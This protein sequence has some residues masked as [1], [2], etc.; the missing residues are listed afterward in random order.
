[1]CYTIELTHSI[2]YP[3]VLRGVHSEVPAE[4]LKVDLLALGLLLERDV[5]GGHYGGA[6]QRG[7]TATRRAAQVRHGRHA[8][9]AAR[10]RTNPRVWVWV[11]VLGAADVVVG[12]AC[13]CPVWGRGPGGWRRGARLQAALPPVGDWLERSLP[14]EVERLLLVVVGAGG[15]ALL[16]PRLFAYHPRL[17]QL[18]TVCPRSCGGGISSVLHALALLAGVDILG[19]VAVDSVGILAPLTASALCPAKPARALLPSR[20]RSLGLQA[21]GRL[22]L[23]GRIER[24]GWLVVS[25]ELVVTAG[26]ERPVR[27]DGS[28]GFERSVSGSF[29]PAVEA[30]NSAPNPLVNV[31]LTLLGIPGA[32]IVLEAP[33]ISWAS[34]VFW[35]PIFPRVSIVF[36]APVV[37]RSPRGVP[38]YPVVSPQ[39]SKHNT[40]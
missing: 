26:L 15:L 3:W 31:C 30:H 28:V 2:E 37:S 36:V 17:P 8:G 33:V 23:R 27:L 21:P 18:L 29:V 20:G 9:G 22:S 12:A 7:P 34:I 4:V 5:A 13:L 16:L 14:A 32:P 6:A 35:T 25:V 19:L 1:M 38:V 40:I 11:V 39:S 24:T 10:Q